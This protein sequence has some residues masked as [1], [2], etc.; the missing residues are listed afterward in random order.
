MDGRVSGPAD[1]LELVAAIDLGTTSAKAVLMNASGGRLSVE[2]AADCG[3]PLLAAEPGWAEQD[4]DQIR[5]AAEQALRQALQALAGRPLQVL[6]LSFSSAMHSLIALD[7]QGRA[8][9]PCITWA[10]QRAAEQARR[11]REDEAL[12]GL[13]SRIGVPVHAMLP[14]CKLVWMREQR[15][16]LHRE[17][18]CFVGIRE[19]VM[20][21]WT[22]RPCR[23]D[24]SIAGG[25]GLYDLQGRRWDAEALE[26]AGIG[27]DRLPELAPAAWIDRQGLSEE[28]A[29]RLGLPAGTPLVLGGADGVLA[30]LG[31]GAVQ[32][33]IAS[34]TVGTSGAVRAAVSR[35]AADAEGRL[36]CYELGEGRWIAGGPVN[37]GGVV[38]RWVRDKLF[39]GIA[40]EAERKGM[41]PYSYLVELAMQT[42]PGADGL[43]CLPH[44]AGERAPHWNEDARGVFVGLSLEH[45]RRHL[46]RAALEGILY[47]L[48]S[49]LEALRETAGPL[50][51][52]RASGGLLRSAPLRQMLADMTGLPVLLMDTAEAS[53]VGA[54]RIALEALGRGGEAAPE[55]P[56]TDRREPDPDAGLTYDRLYGIYRPV[57]GRLA[58]TFRELADIQRAGAD[59]R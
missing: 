33:G 7:G 52:I 30:N 10:D 29:E 8:L 15:P 51:E 11:L 35:P 58:G 20:R 21:G 17:A 13:R 25:T 24:P 40:E 44:L 59:S 45:D 19:Y 37:S 16:Q 55:V 39:P 14:L 2:A 36:F 4:P 46:I 26:L 54:G 41:D 9:T 12:Q 42:P 18:A 34:V 23:V 47:G 22:G 5:E 31:A 53:S 49:V 48:R 32:D 57:F 28:A 1:R 3:Y 6:A 56:I 43:L 50:R 38:F 27:A